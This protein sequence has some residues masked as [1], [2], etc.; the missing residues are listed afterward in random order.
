MGGLIVFGV[1]AAKD[2]RGS[3]ADDP[4]GIS[5]LALAD[6]RAETGDAC[7]LFADL[8]LCEK[9]TDHGHCGVLD[10]DTGEVLNDTTVERYASIAVAQAEAGAH[11]GRAERHDGHGRPGGGDPGGA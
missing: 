6:L 3:A 10:G 5:Q 7:V 4:A 1:P 11:P 2:G 9:Y 8:C